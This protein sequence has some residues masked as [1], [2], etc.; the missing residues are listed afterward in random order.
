[1]YLDACPIR[2]IREGGLTEKLDVSVIVQ[3]IQQ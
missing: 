1:D 2:G 3:T